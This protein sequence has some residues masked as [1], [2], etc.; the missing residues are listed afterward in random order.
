MEYDCCHGDGWTKTELFSL[1]VDCAHLDGNAVIRWGKKMRK[2]STFIF[3]WSFHY[4]WLAVPSLTKRAVFRP[5]P[6]EITCWESKW[7]TTWMNLDNKE[8]QRAWLVLN[9]K[10]LSIAKNPDKIFTASFNNSIKTGVANRP[11]ARIFYYYLISCLLPKLSA[12]KLVKV[13]FFFS[14]CSPSTFQ[15]SK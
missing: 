12:V 9:R 15:F 8:L 11:I 7:A 4:W 3:V 10:V 2:V 6:S 13:I 14:L 1:A 5:S